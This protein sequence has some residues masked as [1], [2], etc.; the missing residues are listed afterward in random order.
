MPRERSEAADRRI[1]SDIQL[2]AVDLDGTLIGPMD[3]FHSYSSF[4]QRLR[5]LTSISKMVWAVNTGR[6]IADFKQVFSPLLHLGVEPDFIIVRHAYVYGVGRYGYWPHVLWNLQTWVA[7][8]SNGFRTRMLINQLVKLVKS[9]FRRVKSKRLGKYKV[10][11]RFRDR[12]TMTAAYRLLRALTRRYKSIMITFYDTDLVLTTIP[13]TKGL[14]VAH[15]ARHLSISRDYILCIGDG[16]NDICML[17]GKVAAMTACPSNSI[18][19]A[20][21]AVNKSNGHISRQPA[22]AGTLEAIEAHL[23]GNVDSTLPTELSETNQMP[24]KSNGS[25]DAF[26]REHSEPALFR[27]SFLMVASCIVLILTLASWNLLGPLSP[28]VMRP[29]YKLANMAA[30]YS[31]VIEDSSQSSGIFR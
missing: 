9:R 23:S 11:L 29:V 4:R 31:L 3:E 15:L 18:P 19:E 13:S 26:R 14:A 28:Y 7:I 20:K 17:D 1:V 30:R 10:Y 6:G 8:K 22:L 25:H 24:Q 5:S 2:I 12:R 21:L 16:Y 27:D